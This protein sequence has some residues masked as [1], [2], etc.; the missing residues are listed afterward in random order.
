MIV[1]ASAFCQLNLLQWL[2][3]MRHGQ[4]LTVSKLS[5]FGFIATSPPLFAIP[6]TMKHNIST[7]RSDDGETT[8]ELCLRTILAALATKE[9]IRFPTLDRVS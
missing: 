7:L 3:L 2:S 6:N 4:I 9:M 8:P 1:Q 5:T